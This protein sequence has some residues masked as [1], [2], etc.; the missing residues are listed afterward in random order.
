[1]SSTYIAKKAA[2]GTVRTIYS[3]ADNVEQ[4]ALTLH[5]HYSTEAALDNLLSYG[6]IIHLGSTPNHCRFY[7]REGG[8]LGFEARSYSSLSELLDDISTMVVNAI[9]VWENGKWQYAYI[10]WG[11]RP[12]PDILRPMPV[13]YTVWMRD[14][15][16]ADYYY[17]SMADAEKEAKRIQALGYATQIEP[18][19]EE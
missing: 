14:S 4:A 1:M 9:Y 10:P 8:R 6:D 5:A 15:G 7:M 3:Y 19:W 13:Q 18:F 2:D 17:T 11:A 12:T 16:E